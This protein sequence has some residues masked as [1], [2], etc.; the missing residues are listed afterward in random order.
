M[1]SPLEQRRATNPRQFRDIQAVTFVQTSAVGHT[2]IPHAVQYA[3]A[4]GIMGEM[5][6][7][8]CHAPAL[9]PCVQILGNEEPLHGDGFVVARSLHF[10]FALQ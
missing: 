4:A 6:Y 9:L 2:P 7:G 5:A 8:Q 3:A 10:V 1:N